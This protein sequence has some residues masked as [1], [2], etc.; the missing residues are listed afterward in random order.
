MFNQVSF[1]VTSFFKSF[2]TGKT[3]VVITSS[4]PILIGPFA[5]LIARIK[6]AVLVYDVRDIWPDVALEMGSFSEESFYCKAFRMIANFMYRH[7]D[8]ITAVSPGKV[9][10]LR[11]KLPEEQQK[12]VWL[13][14][15]G[16]DERFLQQM[17][18]EQVV[19][20]YFQDSR[21]SIVYIGNIGLAQGL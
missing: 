18:D 4:P 19:Q 2:H 10:A 8:I 3:D 7:A 12:K 16:L 9:S 11:A 13:V 17:E 14:E 5:W 20:K 1:G 21:C 15:N 6:H